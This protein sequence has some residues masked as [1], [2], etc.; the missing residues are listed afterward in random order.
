MNKSKRRLY[1]EGYIEDFYVIEEDNLLGEGGSAV[2][3]KGIKKDTGEPVAI[4][5]IDK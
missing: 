3:R 5:I 4:K 2:V 1:R